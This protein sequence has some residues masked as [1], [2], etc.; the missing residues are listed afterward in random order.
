MINRKAS[1]IAH[2]RTPVEDREVSFFRLPD[3]RY[4]VTVQGW[5]ALTLTHPSYERVRE[6]F[7][8]FYEMSWKDWGPSD[9]D[10]G[11]MREPEIKE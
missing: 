1:F 4:R 6:A 7:Q 10:W 3:G 2:G 8:G 5:P 9:I 11:S